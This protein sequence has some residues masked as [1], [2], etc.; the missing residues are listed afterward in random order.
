[1]HPNSFREI[2]GAT[3]TVSFKKG[4]NS[5]YLI[6]VKNMANGCK[7]TPRPH[8]DKGV[9]ILAEGPSCRD[10]VAALLKGTGPITQKWFGSKFTYKDP[11]PK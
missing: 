1:M 10:E 2:K 11:A 6:E 7:Y 5:R 3:A 9:E 4:P 8:K